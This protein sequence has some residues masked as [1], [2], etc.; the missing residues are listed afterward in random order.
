MGGMDGRAGG[1]SLPVR[2]I[3]WGVLAVLAW[4]STMS[5]PRSAPP[6]VSCSRPHRA[7]LRRRRADHAAHAAAH[8]APRPGRARLAAGPGPPSWRRARS[9][10]W[11]V[12]TGFV[13]APLAHGVVLG[14]GFTMLA[15][16]GLGW[17]VEGERPSVAQLSG[18][19]ILALGPARH[20]RGRARC[21]HGRAGVVGRP[22]LRRHRHCRTLAAGDGLRGCAGAGCS[23]TG[24][25]Q[26]NER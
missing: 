5:G 23:R 15:A 3:A 1:G 22:R 10:A 25:I 13:L 21:R 19:A 12:N 24:H 9:S 18:T 20:R 26:P 16:A 11:C 17:W 8:G 14:P 7:A 4:A 2:G 6:R